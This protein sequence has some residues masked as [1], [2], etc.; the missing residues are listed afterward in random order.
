MPFSALFTPVV[1]Y[2]VSEV[3]GPGYVSTYVVNAVGNGLLNALGKIAGDGVG[4]DSV[5]LVMT[6]LLALASRV[7][8]VVHGVGERSLK[9]CKHVRSFAKDPSKVV[10]SGAFF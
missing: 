1:F 6:L 2:V 3:M 10:P 9:A 4:D 5:S 8:G 7:T